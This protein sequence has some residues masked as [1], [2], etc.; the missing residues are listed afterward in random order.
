M[1]KCLMVVAHFLFS[2]YPE[3]QRNKTKVTVLVCLLVVISNRHP[4]ALNHYKAPV[5]IH[6][7]QIDPK[8]IK[9]EIDKLQFI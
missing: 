1:A 9:K 7:L 6:L 5:I 4:P 3:Q 2:N 8:W